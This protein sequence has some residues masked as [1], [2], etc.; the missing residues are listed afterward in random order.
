MGSVGD[1][2]E[3]LV[4]LYNAGDLESLVNSHTE[5]AALVSPDGAARGRAAIFRQWSRD[6]AAFPDRSLTIHMIIEQGD[7]VA[8]EFTWAATNT[9]PLLQP[10]GTELP[11]TGKRIETRGM[12]L[13][14]VR[15]GKVAAHRVYWDAMALAGQ[16]GLLPGR[17]ARLAAQLRGLPPRRSET[18]TGRPGATEAERRCPASGNGHPA[19][20]TGAG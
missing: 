19:L 3:R 1:V 10:D 15:D 18:D 14:R 5:D 2:Y 7:T 4:G 20:A 11:P 17:E 9:G 13:V 12:E 8:S 16:L 6:K